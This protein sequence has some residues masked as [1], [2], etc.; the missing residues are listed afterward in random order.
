MKRAE[1]NSLKLIGVQ[2]RHTRFLDEPALELSM[3]SENYLDPAKDIL[4]DRNFMVWSALDFSNGTIELQVASVLAADAPAYA[5]GF[6]GLAF[7]IENENHF[8][9]VYLRPTNSRADD[10]IRRNR[11]LQYAAYPDFTFD[12][13]RKEEPEKYES[14]CDL[15]LNEWIHLKVT[16]KE[17][18][19]RLYINGAAQPSLV[20][21]DL[22]HGPSSRGGIG[23]WI[24][25]GTVGYFREVVVDGKKVKSL[26]PDQ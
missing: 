16:V 24:E 25:S 23:L 1:K 17:A 3:A 6:I 10:Q 7:R 2:V 13:L 9:N 14:Y 15:A 22:K 21:N 20:V 4:R 5:R 12:R 11:S 18:H 26:N 19:M 8:E